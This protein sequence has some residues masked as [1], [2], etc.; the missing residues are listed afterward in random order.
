MRRHMDTRDILGLEGRPF[1]S[2]LNY[3]LPNPIEEPNLKKMV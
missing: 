3:S 2:R 1:W